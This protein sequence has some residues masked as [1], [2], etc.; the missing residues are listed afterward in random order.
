MARILIVDDESYIRLFLRGTL[1]LLGHQVVGEAGDGLSAIACA[2]DLQPHII[3]L[4]VVMPGADGLS[5]LPALRDAAPAARIVLTT[6]IDPVRCGVA[7]HLEG[8]SGFL[9]KPV[10]QRALRGVLERLAVDPAARGTALGV[11]VP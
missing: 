9:T 10:D 11:P 2:R 8:L 7:G 4:D 6:S 5:I 1:A 3:L